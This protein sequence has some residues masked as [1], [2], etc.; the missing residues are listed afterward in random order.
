MRKAIGIIAICLITGPLTYIN[1]QSML[2]VEIL[3]YKFTAVI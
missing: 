1:A 2:T 3:N